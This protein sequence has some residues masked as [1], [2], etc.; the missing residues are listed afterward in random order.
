[1][2]VLL[3]LNK[4]KKT[5]F[6]HIVDTLI[7]TLS[8]YF[9]F[10]LYAV[11]L[12]EMLTYCANTGI[13]RC[14]LHSL[15]AVSIMFCFRLIQTLPVVSWILKHSRTSS[16]KHIAAWQ[17]NLVIYWLS[18]FWIDGTYWRFFIHFNVFCLVNFPQVV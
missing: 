18:G 6:V 1:V 12:I 10:Q 15:T 9:I 2:V 13:R 7:D 3:N 17:S 14:F 11:K 16:G 4:A 8:N 5:H